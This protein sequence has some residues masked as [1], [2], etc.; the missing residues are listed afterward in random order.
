MINVLEMKTEHFKPQNE[1]NGSKEGKPDLQVTYSN[2]LAACLG[3]VRKRKLNV[4]GKNLTHCDSLKSGGELQHIPNPASENFAHFAISILYIINES[5][6]RIDIRHI[7]EN[8]LKELQGT[9]EGKKLDN[10]FPTFDKNIVKLNY[11]LLVKFAN[12]F[13]EYIVSMKNK[14]VDI[15]KYLKLLETKL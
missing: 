4:K 5:D 11:D 2:L 12:E 10:N 9:N 15:D 13:N 14:G 3:D 8:I 1:Y 6:E 7:D